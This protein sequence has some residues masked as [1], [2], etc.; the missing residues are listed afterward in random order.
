MQFDFLFICPVYNDCE[1]VSWPHPEFEVHREPVMNINH[2]EP[3]LDL[4][5]KVHFAQ[6]LYQPCLKVRQDVGILI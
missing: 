4:L 6:V 2:L 3:L 1:I 5:L